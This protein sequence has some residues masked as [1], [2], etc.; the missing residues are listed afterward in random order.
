M[1]GPPTCSA[2][3]ISRALVVGINGDTDVIRIFGLDGGVLVDAN[4]EFPADNPDDVAI[5]SDGLE[6][7]VSFGNFGQNYG[8]YVFELGLGGQQAALKQTL[9]IGMD[10]VPWGLAYADDDHVV[11]ATAA[12]P[13]GHNVIAIDRQAGGEWA[14]GQTALVPDDWPL[15][16]QRRPGASEVILNRAD[17]GSD[18][19]VDF[20][21]LQRDGTGAW[22][23]A[24]TPAMILDTPLDMGIAPDGNTMFVATD[25]PADPVSSS[26]LDGKGLVHAVP[27]SASGFGTATTVSIASPGSKVAVDPKGAFL[28]TDSPIYEQDPNTGTPISHERRIYTVPLTGGTLGTP[29]TQTAPWPA[30]LLYGLEVAPSGHVILSRQ[31]YPSQAPEAERTPL[32]ILL[33]D[34]NGN[35]ETCA[36]RYL[37]GQGR[38]AIATAFAAPL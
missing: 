38:F 6:A 24:G 23:P 33:P 14:A 9:I 13:T 10:R 26:N 1:E 29:K 4:L 27:L 3:G 30:L 20:Y 35:F 34:G 11:L 37:P 17:L 25:D 19:D 36:T 32:D 15:S 21:R 2:S 7:L 16:L 5:R 31:L 28:I 8:V 18:N 22:K 12:G